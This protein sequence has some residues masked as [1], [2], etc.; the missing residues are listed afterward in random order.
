MAQGTK[1]VC[2]EALSMNRRAQGCPVPCQR[3][4]ELGL[5]GELLQACPLWV[6]PRHPRWWIESSTLL[7]AGYLARSQAL[8]ALPSLL[9]H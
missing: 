9:L 2:E 1:A 4:C 3:C 6:S 7:L 8:A 5:Y